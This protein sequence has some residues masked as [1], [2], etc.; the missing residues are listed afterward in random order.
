MIVVVADTSGLL[1]AID[2]THPDGDG[3][4]RVLDDA[5][6]LVISPALLSELDHVARRIFGRQGAYQVI[7]DVRHRTEEERAV[8][9]EVTASILDTA[10]RVRARYRDLQLDLADAV[11]VAFAARFR[12]NAMLTLDRRDFRA[13]R[14]L[15]D[16]H[17][18]QLLPDDV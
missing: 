8:I 3:A 13:I 15:T 7:E 18:F 14:P 1:A 12:T 10:Q 5:G 11:N 4:R 16:H 17:S 6:T 2:E 9:P